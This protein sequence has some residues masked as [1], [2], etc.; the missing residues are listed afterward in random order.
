M[1]DQTQSCGSSDS[2]AGVCAETHTMQKSFRPLRGRDE[3]QTAG[4]SEDSGVLYSDSTYA[5]GEL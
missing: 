3:S 1:L 5:I 2:G 4:D